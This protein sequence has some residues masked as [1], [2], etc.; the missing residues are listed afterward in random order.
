MN[1]NLGEKNV[2]M[3]AFSD[4]LMVLAL[5]GEKARETE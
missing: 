5:E 2:L 3:N 1:E 4:I